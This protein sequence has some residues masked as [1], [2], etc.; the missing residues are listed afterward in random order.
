[1]LCLGIWY[2]TLHIVGKN[3]SKFQPVFLI[4]LKLQI[5]IYIQKTVIQWETVALQS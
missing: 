5:Y 4:P 1:M 3:Y 2:T